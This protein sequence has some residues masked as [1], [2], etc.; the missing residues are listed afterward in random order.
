M[1][2]KKSFFRIALVSCIFILIN[3]INRAEAKSAPLSEVIDAVNDEWML[4]SG[5]YY[6][7]IT[8]LQDSLSTGI[9]VKVNEINRAEAKSAP[10]SEVIDAEN[11]NFNS[12]E[13][14]QVLDT[15]VELL[16]NNHEEDCY[17]L[18]K[19]NNID[20]ELKN[21]SNK[22]IEK[23][24]GNKVVIAV[25]NYKANVT[26][27]KALDSEIKAIYNT[28]TTTTTTTTTPPTTTPTTLRSFFSFFG[29]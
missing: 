18:M 15:I 1:A 26:D 22:M 20:Y 29:L 13:L 16:C 12:K 7:D 8:K 25:N 10:P 11:L 6:M 21:P 19:K 23:E 27:K 5:H 14:K 3:E 17:E 28:T 4:L 9:L 2:S 24:F